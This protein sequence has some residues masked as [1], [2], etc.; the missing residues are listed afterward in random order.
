VSGEETWWRD[1]RRDWGRWRTIRQRR[2]GKDLW[3]RRCRCCTFASARVGAILIRVLGWHGH[4]FS[5]LAH[6]TLVTH[7]LVTHAL[8]THAL[9]THAHALE[10]S[11]LRRLQLCLFYLQVS[12]AENGKGLLGLRAGASAIVRWNHSDVFDN[13]VAHV[14]LVG[15][16]VIVVVERNP[17]IVGRTVGFASKLPWSSVS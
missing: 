7:A 15:S 11:F 14:V 16:V 12:L 3:K 2:T 9:V 6:H 17:G 1:R 13:V 10:I 4:T 8:V 5:A